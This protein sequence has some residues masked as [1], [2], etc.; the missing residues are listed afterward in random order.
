M[1]HTV[2]KH[3]MKNFPEQGFF[4]LICLIL[5]L[6]EIYFLTSKKPGNYAGF[7]SLVHKHAALRRNRGKGSCLIYLNRS[8]FRLIA[9]FQLHSTCSVS[10]RTTLHIHQ[11]VYSQFIYFHFHFILILLKFIFNYI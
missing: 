9:P 11:T 7:S 5:S 8:E 4:V 2:A 6:Q 10:L 1:H 3:N